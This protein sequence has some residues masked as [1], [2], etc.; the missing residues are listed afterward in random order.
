MGDINTPIE[1]VWK[2]YKYWDSFKTW[3][4]FSQYDEYD[5]EEA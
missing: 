5:T 2:F 1:E 4:E 3:R